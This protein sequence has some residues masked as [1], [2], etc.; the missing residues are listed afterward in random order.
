M[1]IE[2]NIGIDDVIAFVLYRSEN[3]S[4][5]KSYIENCRKWERN[6]ANIKF[7]L[8]IGLSILLISVLSLFISLNFVN[9]LPFTIGLFIIA[10]IFLLCYFFYSSLLLKP[11][12][13]LNKFL[14]SSLQKPIIKEMKK[15]YSTGKNAVMGKHILFITPDNIKSTGESYEDIS[16]W[17]IIEQVVTTEQHLFII[18]RGSEGAFIIP[19]KAFPDD[20]AFNLFAETAKEYHQ[21]AL[22]SPTTL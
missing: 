7:Y 21:A 20:A 19:R 8:A 18:V 3:T 5:G 4:P 2:Y 15:R 10:L 17:D 11:F 22:A 9:F 16:K 14:L 12:I 13:K 6:K 1:E